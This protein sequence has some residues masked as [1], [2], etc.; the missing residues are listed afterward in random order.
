[1]T[2]SKGIGRGVGGG[3]PPK[4]QKRIN[5]TVPINAD[6]VETYKEYLSIRDGGRVVEDED[7]IKWVRGNLYATMSQLDE[8]TAREKERLQVY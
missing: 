4:P 8:L 3:R 7:V 1:M 2:K 5:V 6:R